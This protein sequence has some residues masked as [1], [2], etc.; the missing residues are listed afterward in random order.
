MQREAGPHT[1]RQSEHLAHEMILQIAED[2]LEAIKVSLRADK[3]RDVVDHERIVTACEAV[4][5]CLGRGH[6]AAVVLTVREFASLARL[7]VHEL[8]SD[9]LKRPS[10]GHNSIS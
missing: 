4:A 5:Q 9:I 3:S 7:E 10:L 1:H 2:H 6:I 8:L